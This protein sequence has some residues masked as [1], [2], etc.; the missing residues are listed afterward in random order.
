MS[1]LAALFVLIKLLFD[2]FLTEDLGKAVDSNGKRSIYCH[3]QIMLNKNTCFLKI[4]RGE[5]LAGVNETFSCIY[6]SPKSCHIELSFSKP[7]NTQCGPFP[8]K[9]V[10]Q[11]CTPWRSPMRAPSCIAHS[12]AGST[13]AWEL[14]ERALRV[15]VPS[16]FAFGCG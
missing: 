10:E 5:V 7:R 2:N 14:L 12:T 13:W 4:V 16:R 3:P 1:F 8:A 15:P 11:G 6:A 9:L